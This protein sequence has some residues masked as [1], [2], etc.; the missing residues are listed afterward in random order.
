LAALDRFCEIP[1]AGL[2]SLKGFELLLRGEVLR[3]NGSEKLS[4]QWLAPIELSIAMGNA[5]AQDLL[6]QAG[7]RFFSGH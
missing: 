2:V 1:I 4:G 3:P 5:L 6:S 7:P